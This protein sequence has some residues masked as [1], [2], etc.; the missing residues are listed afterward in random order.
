MR[1]ISVVIILVIGM[2]LSVPFVLERL[3]GVNFL[4]FKD[5]QRLDNKSIVTR[6]KASY[7]KL[8]HMVSGELKEK[9]IDV[10]IDERAP[11]KMV[12][13]W[14]DKDGNWQFSDKAPDGIE[15][16]MIEV[17]DK[18]NTMNLN[19]GKPENVEEK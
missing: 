11:N 13:R 8:T 17:V 12:Y 5:L 7:R 16:E 10:P 19:T 3:P 14:M 4:S 18:I 9:N 15:S 2:L 6:Y 1:L